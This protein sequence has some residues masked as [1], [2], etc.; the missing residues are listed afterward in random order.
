MM[1]GQT[2]A[3]PYVCK[4]LGILWSSKDAPLVVPTFAIPRVQV[5]R[6]TMLLFMRLFKC[7]CARHATTRCDECCRAQTSLCL[8]LKKH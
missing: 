7:M 6:V 4:R 5:M 2:R 3:K 8:N 1:H